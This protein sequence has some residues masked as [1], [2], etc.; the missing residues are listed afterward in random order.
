MNATLE[1]FQQEVID[2]SF[3]TP[4]VVD[5]WAVWCQPC[6]MIG[7]VL[8]KLEKEANG[9]WKLVKV[10]T[11]EEPELSQHFQIRSIPAVKMIRDGK[12]VDEF[13]GALPEVEVRKWLAKHL[14]NE[15]KNQIETAKAML[16]SGNLAKARKTLEATVKQEPANAEARILL[17]MLLLPDEIDKAV[18]LVNGV[19]E[20]SPWAGKANAIRTLH[21]LVHLKETASEPK[22]EWKLYHQGIAAFKKGKYTEALEAWIEL[23]GRNRQLDDDGARKACV[24]LFTLLGSE[25]ELTQKYHRRFT[26]ALY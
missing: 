12:I 9:Q 1:T 7:P 25:H 6:R 21:R 22:E 8:E 19:A 18:D 24:A 11:D 5:F 13:V 14:P 2:A 4:V 3:K 20:D 23:V 16:Q 26:A 17:A 15:S 10:N